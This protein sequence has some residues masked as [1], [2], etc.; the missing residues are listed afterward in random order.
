V[1]QKWTNFFLRFKFAVLRFGIAK[2]KVQGEEWKIDCSG[3]L[4]ENG[5]GKHVD[6]TFVIHTDTR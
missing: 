6:P 3:W 5:K 2:V 1:H 4:L